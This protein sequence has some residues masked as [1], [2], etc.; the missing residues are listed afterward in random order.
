M[1][2]ELLTFGAV[3]TPIEVIVPAL[4]AQ[5]TPGLLVFDT[6]AENCWLAPAA[7]VMFAG[8]TWTVTAFVTGAV[9]TVIERFFDPSALPPRSVTATVKAYVPADVGIP[10]MDPVLVPIARPGGR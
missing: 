6:T 1:L 4:T 3:N 8:E 9:F 5:V 7:R 2:V 10:E